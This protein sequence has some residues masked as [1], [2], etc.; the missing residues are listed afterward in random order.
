MPEPRRRRCSCALRA[1]FLLAVFACVLALLVYAE[2][3]S[4]E[5]IEWLIQVA[6]FVFTVFRDLEASKFGMLVNFV[7]GM[8][9][10]FFAL[11]LAF[12]DVIERFSEKLLDIIAE[13]A[14]DI[15]FEDVSKRSKTTILGWVGVISLIFLISFVTATVSTR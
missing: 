13:I 11:S 8:Y 14:F 7:I 1:F 2:V 10:S 3:F 5:S 12:T 6:L 9:I 15:E 4:S